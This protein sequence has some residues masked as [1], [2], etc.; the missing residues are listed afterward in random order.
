MSAD[1]ERP[2]VGLLRPYP[3][4]QVT[5]MNQAPGTVE[6]QLNAMDEAA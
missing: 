2:P 1:G 5:A 6:G 3:A 4:E